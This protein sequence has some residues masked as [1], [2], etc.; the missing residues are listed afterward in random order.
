MN[1]VYQ[2]LGMYIAITMLHSFS[3]ANSTS[4]AKQLSSRP[5]Q[6]ITGTGCKQKAFSQRRVSSY[7]VAVKCG[8]TVLSSSPARPVLQPHPAGPASGPNMQST[9]RRKNLL[10]TKRTQAGPPGRLNELQQRLRSSSLA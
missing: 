8:A 5:D 3:L 4:F 1:L 9:Q 10:T 2:S 6:S 7:Q